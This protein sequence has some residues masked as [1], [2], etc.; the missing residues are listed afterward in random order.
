[1]QKITSSK[2]NELHEEIELLKGTSDYN[3]YYSVCEWKNEKGR[4]IYMGW[5]NPEANREYTVKQ[6]KDA[7][8]LYYKSTDGK[9]DLRY[10]IFHHTMQFLGVEFKVKGGE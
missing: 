10:E 4:W 9:D 8:Y 1:M 2:I 3:K 7:V 5:Y 6:I